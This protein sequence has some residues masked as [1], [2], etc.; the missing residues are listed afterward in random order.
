MWD[1]VVKVLSKVSVTA[2]LREQLSL[3]KAKSADLE[4]QIA[5]L[6]TENLDLKAQL[7]IVRTDH[8]QTTQELNRLKEEYSEQ[9][10]IWKT[11][12]Y[13]CGKRTFGEWQAFCPK[14]HMPLRLGDSYRMAECS[15][16]CGWT[17]NM[18]CKD[19]YEMIE[20]LNTGKNP[21]SN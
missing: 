10:H 1:W 17:P 4:R 6:K 5:V 13:H 21:N 14:C 8:Q 11:V 16:A 15:G 19:I 12:E 2:M 3:E 18:H 7:Q 20:F 9:V